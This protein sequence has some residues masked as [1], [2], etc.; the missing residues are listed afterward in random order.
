MPEPDNGL[1]TVGVRQLCLDSALPS[2]ASENW[3]C[4]R[5]TVGY[6]FR[7]ADLLARVSLPFEN[8][9]GLIE[10][11]CPQIRKTMA[12]GGKMRAVVSALFPGYF[13]AKFRL[14]IAGRFVASRP[15][16]I[17]LVRFGDVPTPVPEEVIE[18][19]KGTDFTSAAELALSAWTFVPGQ[20]LMICDGPFAGMEAEYVARL[21]DG[22]RALLLIEYLHQRVN[23]VA[24]C[25]I[26][27]SAA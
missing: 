7:A 10:V 11:F 15:G 27:E 8:S 17:G 23:V 22:Q 3:F 2:S 6:E 21:N 13:F 19:M 20:K 1:T 4:V 12:V 16:I 24:Q 25:A 5:S 26:L 9:I 14:A 18:E